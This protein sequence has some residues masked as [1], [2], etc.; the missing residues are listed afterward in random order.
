M[1]DLPEDPAKGREESSEE[2]CFLFWVITLFQE[3]LRFSQQET[4][5]L[6]FQ[7]L[8]HSP[9]SMERYQ[10]SHHPLARKLF[11][12]C[13]KI[14]WKGYYTCLF[15]CDNPFMDPAIYALSNHPKNMLA[16]LSMRM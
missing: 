9:K 13:F 3:F 10:H 16:S 7:P 14:I 12:F 1:D 4:F 2:T 8:Q 5:A 6:S 11:L 15:T